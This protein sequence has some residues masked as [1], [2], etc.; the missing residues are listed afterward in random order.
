MERVDSIAWD[1]I[2]ATFDGA[3]QE[4]LA[5]F[6]AERWPNV[7]LDPCVFRLDGEIVGGCLVML[8]PLPFGLGKVAVAKWGPIFKNNSRPDALVIYTA[9]VERMVE[10]YA[11]ER[12]LMLS[13][14][15]RA[16]P[17]SPNPQSAVLAAKG[18]RV[19]SGLPF[20]NRY[21]VNLRLADDEQRKSF[22]QKWRYHLNK[23][24]KAE[25]EFEHADPARI[26]E[27][28]ALYQVMADRKR[29]PD[30]SAYDTVPQLMAM[31][32]AELRPELFFVRKNGEI[33]A[34]AIIFKA[35]DT[36]VYLY[37]ATNEQALP[38]RAGYF[39][40][41]H[42]IRW[43]RDHTK[44]QWYDLGGTDGF[45]GLHQFKKGMVGD[46]GFIEPVPQM[47]S[48]AESL[49]AKIFGSVAFLAR[50]VVAKTRERLERVRGGLARPDQ[51]QR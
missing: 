15:P 21:V 12:G 51:D 44:A 22:A 37:G 18:F 30:H 38:L 3:V 31:V 41:W 29:F 46:A 42:I 33:I 35:G 26:D 19:G 45:Q 16:N 20:P 5:A 17:V 28:D 11:R 47:M 32:E 10:E 39:L 24:M 40:H 7:D 1:T 9:A 25:L 36:A 50:D 27:F 6:A 2:V 48:Y 49:K 23:S 34:G 43:L 13:I 4:Q 8:Q 14:L